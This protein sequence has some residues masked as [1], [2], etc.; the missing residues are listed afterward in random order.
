MQGAADPSASPLLACL[1]AAWCR[2]CADYRAVMD[3]AAAGHPGWRFA[4]V[5]IEDHA[6]ALDPDDR[7]GPDIT[8]FP[9]LLLVQDGKP[10]FF[11]AVLPYADV[12]ERLLAQANRQALP[13]LPEA[14]AAALAR[15][16]PALVRARPE[17][18]ISSRSR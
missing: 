7:G 5:D 15:A 17:L 10:R 4:W 2:T 9:T 1:C 14:D 11:G 6:D 3:Q 16:V 8:N 13:P 18:L 12:L